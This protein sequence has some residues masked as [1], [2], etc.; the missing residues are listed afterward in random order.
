MAKKVIAARLMEKMV[1]LAFASGDLIVPA[2][3]SPRKKRPPAA[4]ERFQGGAAS[5]GRS[6]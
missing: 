2:T 5:S 3:E 1:L 4:Y 6:S